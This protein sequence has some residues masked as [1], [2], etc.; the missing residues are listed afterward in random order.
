MEEQR[1]DI[2]TVKTG[3][4]IAQLREQ[5]N[6]PVHQLSKLLGICGGAIYKWERGTAMP[7]ID[8]FVALCSILDVAPADI[9]V[10]YNEEGA[11]K[12]RQLCRK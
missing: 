4:K 3:Q 5:K 9:C 11:E 10:F 7:R 1:F 8:N 6:I 2:D 12:F